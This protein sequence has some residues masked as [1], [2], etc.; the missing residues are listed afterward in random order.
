[1][2]LEDF[3]GIWDIQLSSGTRFRVDSTVHIGPLEPPGV[4]IVFEHAPDEPVM[5]LYDPSM[6]AIQVSD[7]ESSAMMY[8]S[9][10]ARKDQAYKAIY[11]LVIYASPVP[12][13]AVWTAAIQPPGQLPAS[14]PPAIVPSSF[15]GTYRVQSTFG[16]PFGI[17]STLEISGNA[18][19]TINDSGISVPAPESLVFDLFTDS[20]EGVISP[21]TPQELLHLWSLATY[22]GTRY[23]YGLSIRGT[24]GTDDW[25]EQTGACGAEEEP[26]PLPDD[27][28][29]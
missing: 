20:L 4:N 1:M 14:E 19:I 3:Y 10:Y 22:K 17:G 7:P 12:A 28:D 5:G 15:D 8:I 21:G 13:L 29:R 16:T 25:P 9:R 18:H 26:P 11:S 24:D 6:E 2:A 27:T 23:L